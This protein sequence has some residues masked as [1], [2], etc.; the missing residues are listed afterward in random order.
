MYKNFP[1]INST[2]WTSS[3]LLLLQEVIKKLD[4]LDKK[5]DQHDCKDDLKSDYVKALEA[6]IKELEGDNK[7]RCE[8]CGVDKWSQTAKHCMNLQCPRFAEI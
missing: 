8:A 1:P 3:E 7:E 4:S 5:F 6:R 2:V